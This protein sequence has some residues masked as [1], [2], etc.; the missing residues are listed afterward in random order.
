L[1]LQALSLS[2][3]VDPQV[4]LAPGQP[5][6]LTLDV[7][8]EGGTAGQLPS[9]EPWLRAAGVR[10]YRERTFSETRLDAQG[11]QLLA[12]R[13]EVYTLVPQT[14]GPLHLPEIRIAWWNLDTDQPAVARLPRHQL[15]G[16][17]TAEQRVKSEAAGA[18]LGGWM[19]WVPLF[20]VLLVGLGFIAGF[21][22][23]ER[24]A[25]PLPDVTR[26]PRLPRLAGADWVGDPVM[27]AWVAETL[28]LWQKRW[29]RRSREQWLSI[30]PRAWR[31]R[32]WLGRLEET[33]GV[34]AWAGALQIQLRQAGWMPP[35]QP[36][37]EA[38]A[39]L[40]PRAQAERQ[41]A[42]AALLADLETARYA[43]QPLDLAAWRAHCLRQLRSPPGSVLRTW[44][45]RLRCKPTFAGR[46]QG[47][48]PLNPRL[49]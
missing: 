11:R 21:W 46:T 2:A 25:W 8:A 7:Q 19:A 5:V 27:R 36:L 49:P 24:R 10:S 1:P 4:E 30:L 33:E 20:A 44:L 3:R 28:S 37:S 29:G 39:T 6:T 26:F 35:G 40:L 31:F 43:R 14:A 22:T 15:R 45:Q 13:T 16:M 47:L 32:A 12:R 18:G 42:L 17:E 48:P 41:R 38:A 9:L 23:R 34:D